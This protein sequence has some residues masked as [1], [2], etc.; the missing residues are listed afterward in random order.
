MNGDPVNLFPIDV[1]LTVIPAKAGI[2]EHDWLR[3][4]SARAHGSRVEPGMTRRVHK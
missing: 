4:S 3:I 2:H 1:G